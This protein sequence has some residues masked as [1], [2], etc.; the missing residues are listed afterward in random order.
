MN[1]NDKQVVCSREPLMIHVTLFS[2]EGVKSSR[3]TFGMLQY[4]YRQQGVRGLFS[5]LVPRLAKVMPACA[6]MISTYEYTKKFF[7]ARRQQAVE[8]SVAL[9]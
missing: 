1:G 8:Q 9:S 6:I 7:H 3:S 4:I 5:G 2:A